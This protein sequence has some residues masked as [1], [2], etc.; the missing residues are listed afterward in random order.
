MA[1]ILPI[2]PSPPRCLRR[3]RLP[4]VYESTTLIV[5]RPSNLPNSV[6]PTVT[7]DSITRQLAS[8]TQVVDE[9]QFTRAAGQ[10]VRPLQTERAR[11]EAMESVIDKLRRDIRVDVNT[12]RNDIT[13]GFIIGLRYR[14][15]KLAQAITASWPS[16]YIDVQ[17][18][19]S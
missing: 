15:P 11:G 9:P 14:D 1:V 6:V 18:S 19:T 3:L 10:Q 12:S 4:D 8:I 5:V 16:K 13:N 7:E 17:T 2:S